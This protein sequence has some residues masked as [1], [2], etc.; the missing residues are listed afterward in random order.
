MVVVVVLGP[1]NI[2]YCVSYCLEHAIYIYIG[3][4]QTLVDFN[5]GFNVLFNITHTTIPLKF[6]TRRIFKYSWPFWPNDNKRHQGRKIIIILGHFAYS[7]VSECPKST[8][9][10]NNGRSSDIQIIHIWCSSWG[11]DLGRLQYNRI[12]TVFVSWTSHNNQVGVT[13]L[14]I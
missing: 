8:L 10:G 4:Q 11:H 13:K 9:T 3:P 14:P 1:V 5:E 7:F 6:E 2:F 12:L